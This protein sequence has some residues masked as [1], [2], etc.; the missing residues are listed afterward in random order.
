MLSKLK[1]ALNK[2]T[3]VTKEFYNKA[4]SKIN[5]LNLRGKLNKLFNNIKSKV[6][7]IIDIIKGY[8]IKNVKKDVISF[9][10][11]IKETY[12][13]HNFYA[14][15]NMTGSHDVERLMS[16]MLNI[17]KNDRKALNATILG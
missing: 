10:E 7:N 8:D 11:N 3:G 4:L 17:T 2:V 13:K 1:D 6:V 14:Q 16:L 12:P 9:F 15:V 5:K